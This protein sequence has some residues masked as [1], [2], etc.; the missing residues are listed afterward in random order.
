MVSLGR[1]HGV[2]ALRHVLPLHPPEHY[3]RPLV[4]IDHPPLIQGAPLW[5][6]GVSN[7]GCVEYSGGCTLTTCRNAPT[8]LSMVCRA[9]Q[10]AGDGWAGWR[11]AGLKSSNAGRTR[12]AHCTPPSSVPHFLSPPQSKYPSPHTPLSTKVGVFYWVQKFRFSFLEVVSSCRRLSS[13]DPH[14]K[15]HCQPRLVFSIG[16]NFVILTNDSKFRFSFLEVV[17]SCRRLSPATPYHTHFC[18][19]R[20]VFS[21]GFNFVIL[22]N[23]SKF[24]FS[25]LEVVSSCRHLSTTN[26]HHTHHCQLYIR[27]VFSIGFRFVFLTNGSKF[28]FSFLDVVS[29]CRHLSTTNP[30]HTHHCQPRLV[31]SIGFNFVFLTNDSKFRFSFLEVVSSCRCLSP[32]TPH[33][34]RHCQPRLVFTIGFNYVSLKNSPKFKFLF[35]KS[36][37]WR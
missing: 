23:I 30:H 37:T 29:S 28:R 13:A 8:P 33:H 1:L 17:S 34:T 20:L 6:R 2:G 15:H 24:R 12:T 27:L 18:H 4:K 5:R 31:F 35:L 11:V 26:P 22:T 14:Q 32:T 3:T 7:S 25:F 21:I 9:V 10:T 19:P 36:L 16:F